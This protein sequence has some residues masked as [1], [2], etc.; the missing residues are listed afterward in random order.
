M[1]KLFEFRLAKSKFLFLYEINEEVDFVQS[2]KWKFLLCYFWKSTWTY[3]IFSN[4]CEI[5]V[6]VDFLKICNKDFIYEFMN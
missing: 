3:K 5:N 2:N 6:G 1:E 4:T